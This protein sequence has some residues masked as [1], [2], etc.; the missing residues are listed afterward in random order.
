LRVE[1]ER[2]F[3][4]TLARCG[5]ALFYRNNKEFV[6]LENGTLLTS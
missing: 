3:I 5:S 1:G 6:T 4:R 2:T